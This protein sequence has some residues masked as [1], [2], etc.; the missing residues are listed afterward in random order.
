MGEADARAPSPQVN[1]RTAPTKALRRQTAPSRYVCLVC[2]AC[3]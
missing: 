2:T 3:S 1:E